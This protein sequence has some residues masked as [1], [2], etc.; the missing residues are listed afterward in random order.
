MGLNFIQ[1]TPVDT[2]TNIHHQTNTNIGEMYYYSQKFPPEYD[3]VVK[4]NVGGRLIEHCNVWALYCSVTWPFNTSSYSVAA[5]CDTSSTLFWSAYART[6]FEEAH[7]P[8]QT[9]WVTF[10]HN[11]IIV[12]YVHSSLSAFGNGLLICSLVLILGYHNASPDWLAWF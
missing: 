12:R 6:S 4:G 8:T 7:F 3:E 11:M 1:S 10:L 5:F 9:V 2:G